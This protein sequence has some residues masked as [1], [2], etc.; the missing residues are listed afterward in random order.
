MSL[1]VLAEILVVLV[2]TLTAD[3]KYRV[4]DGRICH[5]QFECNSLKNEELFLNLLLNFWNLQQILNI[6]KEKM[7]AI[8]NLFPKLQTV[9]NMVRRLYSKRR[10]KTRFDSQH[11]KTS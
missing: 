3:D 4:L 6:L 8:A 9:K 1:L 7:I 5:S 10:F 11:V 2:K